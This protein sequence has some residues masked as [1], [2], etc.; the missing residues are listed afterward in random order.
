MFKK[1]ILIFLTNPLI[2]DKDPDLGGQLLTDP[3]DLVP[4]QK[5]WGQGGVPNWNTW[6]CECVSWRVVLGV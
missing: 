4:D 6:L 3:T 1:I 5:H 2:T